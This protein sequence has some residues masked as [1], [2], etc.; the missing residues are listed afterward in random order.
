M[1]ICFFGDSLTLGTGDPEFRGWPARLAQAAAAEGKALDICNLGIRSNRSTDIIERWPTEAERRLPAGADCR[2][3]FCFGGADTSAPQGFPRVDQTT[4]VANAR[5]IMTSLVY[6]VLWVGP[7][8]M[9]AADFDA[10]IAAL[11]HDFARLAEELNVPYLSLH[12]ALAS[13][14]AYRTELARGDGVHPGADGYARIAAI[15]G[16]WAAWQTW[17]LEA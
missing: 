8:P 5:I 17:V 15:V 13:D 1:Y 3:V 7:P 12:A 16:G 10:R 11:D 4:S 2:L 9:A 14:T 6:P